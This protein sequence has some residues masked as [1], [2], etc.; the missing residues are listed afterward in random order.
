MYY[1][2]TDEQAAA[3]DLTK[4][5]EL[6]L[7]AEPTNRFDSN[8]VK[9]LIAEGRVHIGYVPKEDAPFFKDLDPMPTGSFVEHIVLESGTVHIDF[10]IVD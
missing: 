8:A 2:N 6:I 3:M 5:D 10:D 4:G 7:V 1:R 9:V